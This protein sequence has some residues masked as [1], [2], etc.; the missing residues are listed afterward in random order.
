VTLSDGGEP[1][2][3]SDYGPNGHGNA[4]DESS[5]LTADF[6]FYLPV[7]VGD[8][9]FYDHD[10]DGLQGSAA[11]EPG[12]PGIDVTL[13]DSITGQPV[14]DGA[15]NPLTTTT[16]ANGNY[17]FEELPPGRYHVEFD[18][19]DLPQNYVVTTP[20][21]GNNISI[22]S[23]ANPSTGATDSTPFL[24]SGAQDLT[25]DMGIM[26]LEDVRVG[27]RVWFDDNQDGIQ[28]IGE[29]GVPSIT[30]NLYDNVTGQPVLDAAGNPMSV[31]TDA[32][33]NYLFDELPPGDYYVEFDLSTL[34]QNYLV[35]TQDAGGDDT[36]D[37][38]ADPATG[39][40]APTGLLNSGEQ[41]LTLDMG[42]YR[43]D[44]VEVGDRVWYDDNRDGIQDPNEGGV[45]NVGVTLY[46]TAT[47]MPV[48]DSTGNPVTTVT[49]ANGDYIFTDLPPGDYYVAFDL[50]TLPQDHTPTQQNAG[51]DDT[52]EML[53]RVALQVWAWRSMML[54]PASQC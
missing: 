49:D 51:S 16:D 15:G 10:Q 44:N 26:L 23:N 46:D 45:P 9:V 41:N 8:T 43:L 20:H 33:G 19:A 35:T 6:G 17:L 18:L 21:V 25:L 27:D 53:A 36:L 2:T 29:T 52:A 40:T 54:R 28:D 1:T 32:G 14:L 50:S 34:P 37:S 12:V 24:Y 48:L 42:I 3:E 13:Y 7:T 38:D 22:D 4:E 5:N 47:G 30:V 39:V 11:T 31:L